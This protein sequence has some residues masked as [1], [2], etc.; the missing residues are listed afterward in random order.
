M[1]PSLARNLETPID[2]IYRSLAPVDINSA[3]AP[4]LK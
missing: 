4:V 1:L 3:A 2:G